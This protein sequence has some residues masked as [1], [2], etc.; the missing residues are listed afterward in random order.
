MTFLVPVLVVTATLS[1]MAVGFLLALFLTHR[2]YLHIRAASEHANGLGA[3][4]TGAQ[5]WADETL[6]RVG[7]GSTDFGPTFDGRSVDSTPHSRKS[8]TDKDKEHKYYNDKGFGAHHSR[9]VRDGYSQQDLKALTPPLKSEPRDVRDVFSP[10]SEAG[11]LH[12]TGSGMFDGD[13]VS[14][15]DARDAPGERG[16]AL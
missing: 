14:E 3:I 8:D 7:L 4:I 10:Q 11:E 9:P 15:D 1:A 6:A 16:Q 13:W 2:L 5:S 12:Q